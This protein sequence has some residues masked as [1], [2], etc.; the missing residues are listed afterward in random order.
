[1]TVTEAGVS[2]EGMRFEGGVSWEVTG[3][4]SPT[5]AKIGQVGEV[6]ALRGTDLAL[7]L[8]L[9]VVDSCYLREEE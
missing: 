1:M 9:E 4:S 2:A 5:R 6:G 7:G 8:K 3:S